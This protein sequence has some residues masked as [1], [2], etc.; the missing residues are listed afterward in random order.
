MQK[1]IE[2]FEGDLLD[3]QKE[4]NRLLNERLISLVVFTKRLLHLN[5]EKYN[6]CVKFI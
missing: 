3:L 6:A 4:K 5:T 1:I 2:D